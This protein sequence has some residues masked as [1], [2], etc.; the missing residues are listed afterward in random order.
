MHDQIS[1]FGG[2]NSVSRTRKGCHLTVNFK[3]G[4]AYLSTDLKD[5]LF[6]EN[7]KHGKLLIISSQIE[8]NWYMAKSNESDNGVECKLND[9]DVNTSMRINGA[10]KVFEKM[11]QS[12]NVTSEKV[13]FNV[14][15][16]P[17]EF[18]G[19]KLYKI[20]Y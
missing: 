19:L 11:A 1:I 6:G 14:S 12:M 15:S 20:T 16:T 3:H 7:V 2:E 10:Q 8:K 5:I 4:N 13:S 18:Q 9:P 17:I